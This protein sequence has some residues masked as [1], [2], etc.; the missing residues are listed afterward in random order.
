MEQKMFCF[1]CQEAAQG[2]GCIL[3]G[4]CGKTAPTSAAM[5]LLLYVVK[6]ISVATEALRT[7]GQPV[8]SDVN[9]FVT[10]A[11]FSTITNANFDEASIWQRV[12]RGLLMRD[13]LAQQAAEAGVTLPQADV[14]IWHG[15]SDEELKAKAATVGVTSETDPDKRSL[16]ELVLYGLKG[17]AA[18][19]DHAI[20]LGYEDES[21]HAFL[22]RALSQTTVGN[23]S[24]AELTALASS[25]SARVYSLT[26]SA[27]RKLHLSAVFACNFVNHCYTLA[28]NLLA[29]EGIPFE[30]LLPLIDETAAKVHRLSPAEAQTGPAVRYD[31]N[32]LDAQLAQ[33]QDRPLC[34]DI[35]ELMSRSIHEEAQKQNSEKQS[36]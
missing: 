33:L 9:R 23:L 25:V 26:S 32:V 18:Y 14:L 19:H 22:Q 31:R 20:R 6:G 28:G 35:Y 5:D 10:D 24:V 13:S 4:V 17:M 3:K 21:I 36:I 15:A 30:A 8:G 34:H 16:K 2:K 29:E 27:R 1:Q 11:L 7:N 12:Q